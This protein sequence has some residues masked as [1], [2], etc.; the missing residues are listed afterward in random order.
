VRVKLSWNGVNW[1]W[2]FPVAL[3]H[4]NKLLSYDS[5]I[6]IISLV[7]RQQD[8]TD[9][10]RERR[11]CKHRML[12]VKSSSY[13]HVTVGGPQRLVTCYRVYVFADS[14]NTVRRNTV[15][16]FVL[17]SPHCSGSFVSFLCKFII[18]SHRDFVE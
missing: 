12:F 9:T 3:S 11:E 6:F 18:Q 15:T 10:T 16:H 4:C 2:K 17:F 5:I 13:S 14:D 8:W 1:A 7:L